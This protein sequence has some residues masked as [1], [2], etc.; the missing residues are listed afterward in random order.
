MVVD[1]Q[2]Q[3]GN[4][5]AKIATYLPGRTDNDVKNFWSTRQKRLARIVR[6]PLPRRRSGKHNN[7]SASSAPS[8]ELPT[9]KDPCTGMMP[10]QETMHHI[11]Q[12][13]QEPCTENQCSDAPCPGLSDPESML[14]SSIEF[15]MD[16]AAECSSY[17]A[18][19]AAHLS[20][21]DAGNPA[22]MVDPAVFVDVASADGNVAYQEPV[23]EVQSAQFFGLEEDD[24]GHVGPVR[25]DMSD[26]MFDDLPPDIFDF[27]EL[28]P[29]PPSTHL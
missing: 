7:G 14:P 23:P 26:V 8:H 9:S 18:V 21:G 15:V 1:L 28:P 11:G 25:Q 13:S 29:S 27:F 4:K 17:N 2:A 6:A 5:W 19:P 16:A 20:F 3:F 12:S 24:Y 10:F 22:P